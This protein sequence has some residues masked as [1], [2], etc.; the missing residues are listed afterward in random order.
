[1]SI[2]ISLCMIVKNE[3]ASLAR[4]L[5][6]S[7]DLVLEM[8]VLDTGSTDNTIAVAKKA[9]ARV[10]QF[11]WQNDFAAARNQALQYVQGDWVL[12][13]DA[14]EVL[15][16]E[17]VPQIQQAIANPQNLVVN[18]VRQ[19]IGAVQSP[20]SLLS[21]LFR[22]HRAVHFSRP[23]HAIIDDS[24]SKLLQR[25]PHWQIVSL[26][27]IAIEHYGYQPGAI[28]AKD[29]SRR[30]KE[31]MEA[32][33]QDNPDDP[34]VCSKLGALYVQMGEL[35]PGIK[36]LEHGL[37]NPDLGAPLLFELNYHLG[38]AYVRRQNV[39]QAA[40]HYQ[41]AIEQPIL[42]QLKLGAYNNLGS[43][44]KATE[45]FTLAKQVYTKA[46]QI[47]PNFAIGHYNLGMTLK[48][49]GFFAEAIAAYKQAIKLQ[50]DY[51]WAYQNLGVT[52]LKIGKVAESLSEFQHAIA[53]HSAQNPIEA[54]RL[55]QGLA[56]MGFQLP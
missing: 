5:A 56:D 20:Y 7:K 28:A 15:T 18:L 2:K 49:M 34:Y 53:L 9:G 26:A 44:F 11:P 41:Q 36:L 27:P 31:A 39:N 22:R 1:M 35:N 21:R 43:L 24:V 52:L 48:A 4:C 6:S 54:Q 30:A 33:I 3:E 25:E 14:D 8:V 55:R 50:P 17:I 37:D 40:L 46:L 29:K 47:D 45:Q 32:Y 13:L 19:E 16:P 10:Y 51:A 12:V 23:Y 42:P 38:N